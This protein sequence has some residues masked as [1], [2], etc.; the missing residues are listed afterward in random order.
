MAY[1][2]DGLSLIFLFSLLMLMASVFTPKTAW[3]F[4]EKSKLRGA[5]LWMSTALL[6]AVLVTEFAPKAPIALRENATQK[7]APVRAGSNA[8]PGYILSVKKEEAGARLFLVATLD[9][10]VEPGV[11]NA[12]A[13]QVYAAKRGHNYAQVFIHWQIRTSGK[14]TMPWADTDY[15]NGN[16]HVRMRTPEN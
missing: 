3:F 9:E 15:E 7:A 10:A 14:E 1:V 12:L 13:L 11:L 2:W 8:L 5:I 6:S 16:W 4:K